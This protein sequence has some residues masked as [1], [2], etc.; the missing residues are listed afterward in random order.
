[1]K[2]GCVGGGG[3]DRAGEGS[4]CVGIAQAAMEL[5]M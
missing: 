4:D 3:G 1:M 5:T 2:L